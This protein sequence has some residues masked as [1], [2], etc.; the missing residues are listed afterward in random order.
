MPHLKGFDWRLNWKQVPCLFCN[1]TIDQHCRDPRTGEPT[2]GI[3][4]TRIK[5][6]EAVENARRAL[7][8]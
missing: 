2:Q 6:I 1:A 4:T 7:T 8:L 3:H 5:D